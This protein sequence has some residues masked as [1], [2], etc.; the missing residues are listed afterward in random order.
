MMACWKE[1]LLLAFQVLHSL[2]ELHAGDM[3]SVDVNESLDERESIL[4][5][6]SSCCSRMA[7]SSS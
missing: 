4:P 2:L 1:I 5:T 7:S 6:D 3:N